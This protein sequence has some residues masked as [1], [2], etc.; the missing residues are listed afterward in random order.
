MLVLRVL[1]QIIFHIAAAC[2]LAWFTLNLFY[3]DTL[4]EAQSA[5]NDF[6]DPI[7]VKLQ[8]LP[9]NSVTQ[10]I[11]IIAAGAFGAYRGLVL[12][13]GPKGAA[14]VHFLQA[15]SWPEIMIQVEIQL[16]SLMQWFSAFKG[17][18]AKASDST[19][20]QVMILAAALSVLSTLLALITLI[21]ILWD[22]IVYAVRLAWKTI[23][24]LL[25][26]PWNMSAFIVN[27]LLSL[28]P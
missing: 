2:L 21:R 1:A 20:G 22:I 5:T 4:R 24:F 12:Y 6:L 13:L 23:T 17:I 15:L 10:N 11:P 14:L 26:L 25:W 28:L 3:P 9:V 16:Y 27:L 18:I 8:E 19:S 7:T